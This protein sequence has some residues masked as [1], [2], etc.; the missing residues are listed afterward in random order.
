MK[1]KLT[2]GPVA[3]PKADTV[4]KF[5][6]MASIS[7]EEGEIT[8]YGD[9][10]SQQPIDW[11]TG[12]PEPGLYIT[13]EGFMEDLAAV[14]DKGRI[15]VRLNSCGGDLYTGI[16]IHNALKSLPGQVNVVGH[17]GQ[18][19]QRD[20]V[21]RRYRDGVPRIPSDDSWRERVSV[22]YRKY[23]GHET[24]DEKHGC[25]RTGGGGNL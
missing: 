24:A 4:P 1:H 14:R 3:V 13:P 20:H 2:M 15:T 25:Q 21:R 5:W 23:P 19:G 17:C 11:W 7:D 12:E 10:M 22:G 8:L 9:V 16:A 6:N 18:R